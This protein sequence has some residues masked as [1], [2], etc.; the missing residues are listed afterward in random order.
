MSEATARR[1]RGPRSAWDWFPWA[2][3]AAL[4][5]VILINAGMIWAALSTFPGQAGP[6][7]FDVS[8]GYNQ[9]LRA[10]AA[11]RAMGWRVTLGVDAARRLRVTLAGPDG[12]P[13][14]G[15]T[16][17]AVAER[18]VGPRET[19]RLVLAPAAPGVLRATTAL[20]RGVWQVALTIHA[21][22]HVYATDRRLIVMERRVQPDQ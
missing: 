14:G 11:Q 16:A 13:L 20:P 15:G 12:K 21:G 17:E 5:V 9:V 18:P 8:N 19:T 2:V 3:A 1:R 4:V 22:G 6:D 7:G 10:A